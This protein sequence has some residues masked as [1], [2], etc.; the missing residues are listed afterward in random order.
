MWPCEG[1]Y[2][3]DQAIAQSRIP[4]YRSARANKGRATAGMGL[5]SAE[6]SLDTDAG[7]RM[8]KLI[9]LLLR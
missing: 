4:K 7:K 9:K 5:T 1:Q 3:R 6:A 8:A 2:S